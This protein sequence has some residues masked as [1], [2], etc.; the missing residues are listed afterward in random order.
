MRHF[1]F[2]L[3]A[4][5]ASEAPKTVSREVLLLENRKRFSMTEK[6]EKV[7]VAQVTPDE[8]VINIASVEVQDGYL[9]KLALYKVMYLLHHAQHKE[10]NS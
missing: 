7:A 8:L 3:A 6:V 9:G 5:Q 2:S 4:S 10:Q 1:C